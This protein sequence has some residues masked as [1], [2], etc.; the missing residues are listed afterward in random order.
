MLGHEGVPPSRAGGSPGVEA[1]P[2][3]PGGSTSRRSG[4]P[5]RLLHPELGQVRRL[6]EW[7]RLLLAGVLRPQRSGVETGEFNVAR[8]LGHGA[9]IKTP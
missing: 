7:H 3:R 2:W 5:A 1:W 9:A 4:E 8:I 6:G